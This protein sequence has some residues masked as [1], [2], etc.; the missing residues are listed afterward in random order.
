MGRAKVESRSKRDPLPKLPDLKKYPNN[1]LF[2]RK[3][4]A[5][6]QERLKDDLGNMD[7]ARKNVE[8]ANKRKGTKSDEFAF[9]QDELNKKLGKHNS[10]LRKQGK[11]LSSFKAYIN[12]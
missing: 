1:S 12:K 5:A 8:R 9:S 4:R 6:A 2:G 3:K 7:E 10:K 11:A